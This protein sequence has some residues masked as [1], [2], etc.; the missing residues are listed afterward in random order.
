MKAQLISN[1]SAKHFHYL[2]LTLTAGVVLMVACTQPA[3]SALEDTQKRPLTETVQSNATD[4]LEP[5]YTITPEPTTTYT[6]DPTLTRTLKPNPTSLPELTADDVILP[7]GL[8]VE[9]FVYKRCYINTD[10]HFHAGDL[11]YFEFGY[12]PI[13]YVVYAPIDGTIR[14][15]EKINDNV[16]WEIRVET[17]LTYNGKI[18]WYDMVHHDGLVDGLKI[19]SFVNKGEPIARLYTARNN[20][21]IEKAVDVGIRNGPRGPNPQV[22]PFYPDS[23][24]E[25]FQFVED[26]LLLKNVTYET[27]TGNPKN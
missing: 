6:P 20:G 27:H 19:G 5:T 2:L 3:I 16:G 18:V 25:F 23:Y 17:P 24:I 8:E 4:T 10:T 7:I 26:D 22:D 14:F 11:I 1:R 13:E 12:S 21:R 9:N 15:A